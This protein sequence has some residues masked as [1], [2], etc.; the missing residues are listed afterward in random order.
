M[1]N[2]TIIGCGWLGFPL[3]LKLLEA[4]N[5]IFGATQSDE[6]KT[7]LNQ[8]GIIGF[9]YTEDNLSEIPTEAK[10][11]DVLIINFP[12]S[13]S[14]NYA[15]QV[16]QLIQQ[17]SSKTKVIFTSSTGIYEDYE[18]IVVEESAI[19]KDHP[20]YLAEKCVVNSSH[21]YHILRLAGL[22]DDK[23]HPIHF[24]SGKETLNAK[25][26]VNL[27]HKL[28]V[29]AAIEKLLH[30]PIENEVFNVC[31]PCHPSRKEYYTE[32]ACQKKIAPPIFTTQ[33]TFGKEISSEKIQLTL[34][35]QLTNKILFD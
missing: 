30:A 1:M 31:F 19:K 26:K 20:V 29:I 22:I 10:T 8:N 11:S 27:V 2:I 4:G 32:T 18:G 6:K 12:P 25:G 35:F 24:L 14:S 5:T 28:D 13:K 15:L 17:F 7:L 33:G 16:A 3:G 9:I 21:P 23:R 34:D